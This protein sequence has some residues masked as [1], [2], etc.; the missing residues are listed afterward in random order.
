[1]KNGF[2][3]SYV[4]LAR[5]LEGMKRSSESYWT[6]KVEAVEISSEEYQKYNQVVFEDDEKPK[7]EKTLEAGPEKKSRKAKTPKFSS[8]EDFFDEQKP[9]NKK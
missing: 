9:R 2:V 8:L 7:K 5:M 4:C 6:E 1:M 3:Y